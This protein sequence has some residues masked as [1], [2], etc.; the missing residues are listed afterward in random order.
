MA[1]CKLDGKHGFDQPQIALL[2]VV[3]FLSEQVMFPQ[4]YVDVIQVLVMQ[5]TNR[6]GVHVLIFIRKN[7]ISSMRINSHRRDLRK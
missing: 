7:N 3:N 6:D 1:T 4:I 5:L 2:V